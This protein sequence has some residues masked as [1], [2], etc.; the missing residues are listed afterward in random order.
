[1]KRKP[2]YV[3]IHHTASGGFMS[4]IDHRYGVALGALVA[5]ITTAGTLEA[6]VPGGASAVSPG[7]PP[8]SFFDQ[9]ADG[10]VTLE[11]FRRTPIPVGEHEAV[12][13]SIDANGDGKLT[14]S[15]LA[16]HVPPSMDERPGQPPFAYLDR[17][18]DGVL[19]LAEFKSMPIPD[20]EHGMVFAS[21]DRNRDGAISE[22]ELLGHKAPARVQ[23]GGQP[24]LADLDQD[25]DGILTL[26]EFKSLTIPEGKHEVVFAGI[27]ANGDGRITSAELSD[28]RRPPKEQ[29]NP[30]T[31][32]SLDLD[33]DGVL[34]R[35]EFTSLPIPEGRHE[36]IFREMDAD[37]DGRISERE[38]DSHRRIAQSVRP[39]P[40]ERLDMPP[41]PLHRTPS[42][43]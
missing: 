30:P 36:T 18:R 33:G 25:G 20:G 12:F 42:P 5:L 41:G 26:Q 24:S 1:M 31:F 21:M 32:R 4:V 39:A 29:R 28:H 15:E 19:T 22:S 14:E 23:S 27:D 6:Q 8:F 35:T 17:D 37:D 10:A 16:S 11:E 7:P 40:P 13:A 43:R 2:L 38:F 3:F 9:D 34:T